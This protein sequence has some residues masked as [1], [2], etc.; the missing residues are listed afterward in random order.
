MVLYNVLPKKEYERI[1]MCNM[2]QDV[3]NSLIITHQGNKQVK[4]NKIDLFIQKYEEFI[5]SDDESINCA[6]SRFNTIITS[7]K[8]LDESFSSRNHVRKFLRALHT[9]W[10]PKVTTIEES[11]D[12]STLSL[13]ELIGNLKVYEVV[14]ENDLEVSKNKKEKEDRRCFKCGD[15]N[16]FINDCPKHSF[17]DQKAFVVGCWS[18]SEDDSKKEEICLM[19]QSNKVRL[20]VN[21]E[22]DEWIKDSGCTKH[23][24]GNKDLF[25]SYK[26][27]DGGHIRA[28][29]TSITVNGKNAYEL[30]GKFLDDLHKNAFSGT[31]GED[32]VEHIEYF[33]KIVDPINL[34][35]VNQ[36]KLRVVVFLIS[37]VGDAWRWFDGIKGSIT[38]LDLLTKDI[39]VFKTYEEF[40]DDW[41][42]EL[43]NDVPWRKDGYCNGGN[44][45]GDYIVRNTLRYQYLEW[46]EALKDS[47]LKEEALRNKANMK[48]LINDDVKSN[49]KGWKSWENFEN[50]NDDRYEREYENDQDDEE[51]CELFDDATQKLP[52]CTVRRFEMIK[53]SFRQDEEYVVV[54]ED[55]YEDLTSTRKKACRAYQEIFRMTVKDEWTSLKAKKSMKLVKY[56]SSGILCVIVVMLVSSVDGVDID[57]FCIHDRKE[58]VVELGYGVADLMYYHFLRPRLGLDYG[59]HPLTVDADVL[60]LAKTKEDDVA[61]ISTSIYVSNFPEV[62]SA[63]D[64]FHA[65]KKYGHVI[66]SFIPFKKSKDGKRFGFVR[67]INVFNMER[68]HLTVNLALQCVLD[69][70]C[71]NSRDLS[72]TLL[73]RVKEFAS[74]S[75]LKVVLKNEGFDKIKLQYMGELYVIVGIPS[76]KLRNYFKENGGFG[77]V[78]LGFLKANFYVFVPEVIFRGKVFVLR[79]KEIPGW[80]PEFADEFD[81]DDESKEGSKGD[82][83]NS[84]ESKFPPGFTPNG[85]SMQEDIGRSVNDVT[86]PR[87]V[88]KE[89]N[90]Q[91]RINNYNSSKDEMSGSVC[92]GI[93]KKP[94][95]SQSGSIL[96]V[97]EE[98]V[99]VVQSNVNSFTEWINWMASLRLQSKVKMMIQGV[100]FV[101]WWLVW[102]YRN[103]LLFEEK[104]PSK[105]I[106]F[107]DVV[108]ISFYWYSSIFVTPKKGVVIAIDNHL[109]K[110]SIEID[111]NPDVNRNLTPMCHRNLTKE[112]E[113]V[114]AN[115][116]L[117]IGE[118][119]KK[120]SNKKPACSHKGPIVVETDDPFDD[121]DEILGDY[122]NTRKEII[123]DN[124]SLEVDADN[125]TKEES[126]ESDTK[127]NDTSGSDSEDL[128]Y[129]P[130]HDEVFD[131]DE[132]ILEDVPM[133]LIMTNFGSDLDDGIDSERRTQLR[134]LKRIGKAKNQDPNK[135]YFYDVSLCGCC[136]IDLLN[137]SKPS[138]CK[139]FAPLDNSKATILK[140]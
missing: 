59:L 109:R 104:K 76:S 117:S 20:K 28:R 44:L 17:G 86:S 73:G 88:E 132:H 127:E 126:A 118:L 80:V 19:A 48:G 87:I 101:D 57:E 32:K 27:I 2:A 40:K 129:D 52:V 69:D 138:A 37:L 56:Q 128:D 79:A 8:A 82:T 67:F 25:S 81:D 90:E 106:I 136:W 23:M 42:Y 108:S 84:H 16:H 35:N 123:G 61:K 72:K 60:E 38:N 133:S 75:N 54:K 99:K 95:A 115:K 70:D 78:V 74:L 96:C 11:K 15:P 107:D 14:L 105:A 130:K 131:D 97:L 124:S 112:W 100:F 137:R 140:H 120:L 31:N 58:M 18:D 55:E 41:I 26:A 89:H 4:D 6:F 110:A 134:E 39:E 113:E 21:L 77:S 22:P 51:R 53:Y 91:E 49:N 71:L 135:Y 43:N 65:C 33:L 30:K 24:T 116:A 29:I 66:D 36:D 5:I 111:S 119:L 7:L 13:D 45:L 1:F 68:L 125:E 62:F 10:R 93:F 122:A 63:K 102:S 139:E 92:S 114:S 12:L 47:E 64:L 103:K 94:V 9:K 3:W 121:L 34:P 83:A 50:I 46:Y 98:L 85:V